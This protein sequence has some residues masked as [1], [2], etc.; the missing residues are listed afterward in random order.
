MPHRLADDLALYSAGC[1][2]GAEGT[3][4]LGQLGLDRLAEAPRLTLREA[5]TLGPDSFTLWSF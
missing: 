1:L 3:A 5:R 4:S 2:I